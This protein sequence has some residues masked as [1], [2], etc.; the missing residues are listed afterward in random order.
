MRTPVIAGNWKMFKNRDEAVRFAYDVCDKLPSKD[1]VETVVCAPALWLR[2][3]IKRQGENLRIGAQNLYP[4]DEG[5]FTGEVSA[6]MLESINVEYSIIGH[7]ER[8]KYFNETDE[9]VNQKVLAALKHNIKPIVCV[10]ES[11]DEEEKGLTTAVLEKQISKAFEGVDA[12]DVANIIVAYEPVWAIGT[13]AKPATPEIAEAS[14]KAI[15]KVIAKLYSDDLAQKVRIL[16]GGSANKTN[17]NNYISQEDV[18]GV[19]L[20]RASLSSEDY[21]ELV[22]L[23]LNYVKSTK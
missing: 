20:G 23:G 18:D 3:L 8:R 6:Y 10:G 15:R 13:G 22:N 4:V 1:L 21:L 7:S 16:Y 9:L 2:C 12:S 5:A 14:C 17:F 11:K 19:L